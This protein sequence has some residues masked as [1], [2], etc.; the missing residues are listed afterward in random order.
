MCQER[1][2]VSG[3]LVPAEAL[4]S[5]PKRQVPHSSQQQTCTLDTSG[6][7]VGTGCLF[8]QLLDASVTRSFI[9]SFLIVTDT[10][11][12]DFAL[13]LT[14]LLQTVQ[15]CRINLINLKE[16]QFS[17]FTAG[18]HTKPSFTSVY[19]M[20]CTRASALRLRERTEVT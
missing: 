12:A 2:R 15:S 7:S 3:S 10:W 1:E 13:N 9:I 17:A 5:Y 18:R 4:S 8:K 16:S 20:V 6:M 11:R 19:N 14:S